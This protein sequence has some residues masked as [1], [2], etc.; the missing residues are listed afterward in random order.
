MA[1]IL[2]LNKKGIE[3]TPAKIIRRIIR[4]ILTVFFI[5]KRL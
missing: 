5:L 4:R 3:I 2:S 1:R